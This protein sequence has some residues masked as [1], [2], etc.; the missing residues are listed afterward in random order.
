MVPQVFLSLSGYDDAFVEKVW[1]RLPEGLALFYKK[2]FANGQKLL[3]AMEEGVDR[4]SVFVL[5]ASKHSIDS[6]WVGFEV[7]QAR[8]AKIQ[9]PNLRVLV[10]P[11]SADITSAVLPTWMR[12][13][14]VSRAGWNPQD[15]ARYVRHILTSPPIAPSSLSARVFGRGQ[16]LDMANQRL[17]TAVA[18]THATPNVLV[19]TG[20]NG[21]GRRT[22]AR[23]LLEQ[24]LPALPELRFGPELLL[25]QFADLADLYRGLREQIDPNFSLQ[26]FE[27]DLPVFQ[28]MS[29]PEQVEEVAN[30][31]AYFGELGQAV[32]AV[33]GSGLFEDRGNPKP[34]VRPLFNA[35]ATRSQAKLCIVA[36]RQFREE[37]LRSHRNVFQLYVPPLKDPDIRA[38]I[39]FASGAFGLK[40]LSPSDNLV[41]AIG[42]HPDI[43]KAAVRLIAQRGEH[44]L[45]KSPNILFS[46][47]DEILSENLDVEALS[48]VQQEV[49]CMLSWVPR[50]SGRILERVVMARHK[51]SGP[52]FAESIDNLI[53]GCLV[54]VAGSGF[55]ISSAIR[56]MFRR[57]YGYGPSGLIKEFSAALSDEWRQ[58]VENSEFRSE[59][60]DAFVFMHALEGKSLPDELQNLLLPS[61]LQEVI[62]E[63]YARGR[64]DAE[65]LRRVVAWGSIAQ[66]MKLDETVREE[67]LS[68]VV[69]AHIRLGE[70]AAAEQFMKLFDKNGYR[71]APFLRGFSLRR[72]DKHRDALPFL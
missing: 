57:R 47:Q 31:I 4:S 28:N 45:E 60:F 8:L 48:E 32:F 9:R 66:K 22:F 36:H 41:S 16:H 7:D 29:L 14:W 13:Y 35:L 63:T 56:E 59:L 23:Y 3:D 39:T 51:T 17:M 34:W 49:L 52:D 37:E 38:L 61:T 26:T 33:T 19:F 69:R 15:I 40:P 27:R 10:F 24:S 42:G 64:D 54:L 6:C 58:S 18:E 1:R 71:S 55:A 44:I 11:L 68:S 5:F 20:V 62:R 21:I 30:S 53:L 72:Q 2:S 43:A 70:Y 65:A 50:L 12:Q 46:V 25:P 67:I